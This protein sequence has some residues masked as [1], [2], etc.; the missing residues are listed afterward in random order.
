MKSRG[1][2]FA[3]SP[4][5]RH[6]LFPSFSLLLLSW[7]SVW[8][9]YEILN[10]QMCNCYTTHKN[11]TLLYNLKQPAPETNPLTYNKQP[12]NLFC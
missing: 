4:T 5:T 12:G 10:T 9:N 2:S 7:P 11:E 3:Y 1:K 6:F 8:Y